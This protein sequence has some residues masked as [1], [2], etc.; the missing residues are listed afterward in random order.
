LINN[1]GLPQAA[2]QHRVAADLD[3]Q[4]T[5]TLHLDSAVAASGA[6]GLGMWVFGKPWDVGS[7]RLCWNELL[8]S[9]KN[10]FYETSVG[11][12]NI[13]NSLECQWLF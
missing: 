6:V 10:L 3:L 4:D 7:Y 11:L 1:N 9:I 5:S 8:D 12:K 2:P 13:S